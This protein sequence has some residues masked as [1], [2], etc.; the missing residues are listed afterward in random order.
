MLLPVFLVSQLYASCR[1]NPV[2]MS[3]NDTAA[4]A[5]TKIHS[6]YAGAGYGRNMIYLE[7]SISSGKPYYSTML[8]YGFRS[9]F[10]ATAT[11]SSIEGTSP[12]IAF[13]SLSLSYRHTFNSWLDI[14][15]D[16]AG[17]KTSENLQQ[18]LFNDF[19]FF[20][21]TSGFDWNILY[22]KLSLAGVHSVNNKGY[23][24]LGNSHYFQTPAFFRGKAF[25]SFDPEINILFGDI[26]KIKTTQGII[27][28]G[29]SSPFRHFVRF[30]TYPIE[31]VSSK[32]GLM[33]IEFSLPV[34]FNFININLEAEPGYFLPAYSN[35]QYPAPKGFTFY[36]TAIIRIL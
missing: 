11:A 32:F 22:T 14:S 17:Y 23:I 10:Y 29:Y 9:S 8:T 30:Q 21:F 6:L 36:L 3:D 24:Q 7:S 20:S 27:R 4:K 35:P 12:F 5:E 28:Y 15:A 25:V 34:T 26:V 18:T 33:D 19:A 1:A 13:S 31:S 16:L 2:F